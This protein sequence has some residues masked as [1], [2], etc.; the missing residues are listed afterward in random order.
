MTQ[1]VGCIGA[2]VLMLAAMPAGAAI[3]TDNFDSGVD[4]SRWEVMPGSTYYQI[5]VGDSA[6]AFGAQS[7]KQVEA[8]PWVYYM[9]TTSSAFPNP[10]QLT[11]SQKEVLS[12]MFFDDN[13]Q[14]P[15]QTAGGVMLANAAGNDFFQIS[16]NSTAAGGFTKYNWRTR[17]D[18][19]IATNVNRSQGWHEF[20]IEVYPYT[21]NA[22]DVKFYIDNAW[23]ADGKRYGNYD[24]D[25]I[26]LGISI[27]SPGSSFWYDNVSLVPEPATMAML[28]MGALAL[29]RRRR[30]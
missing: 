25:S 13:N 17:L 28:G 8:D 12:V 16:V 30:A 22:G 24:L 21:G 29:L 3:F 15:A 5:L 26:R 20:K 19:T 23:V 18:G 4:G 2:S 10:G 14:G 6:H 9:R 1:T 7:A 11:G 27:K